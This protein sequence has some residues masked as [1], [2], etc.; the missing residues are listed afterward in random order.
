M[1]TEEETQGAGM[2]S[3]FLKLSVCYGGQL[4]VGLESGGNK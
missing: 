4:I 3:Q 1:S 2:R